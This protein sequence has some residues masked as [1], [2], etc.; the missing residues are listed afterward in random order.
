MKEAWKTP[1]PPGNGREDPLSSAA[2][3]VAEEA[4][5]AGP[6]PAASEEAGARVFLVSGGIRTRYQSCSTTALPIELLSR[7][8]DAGNLS[9]KTLRSPLAVMPES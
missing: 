8:P 3:A 5:P 4:V 7:Q 6:F 9:G 2:V 1:A